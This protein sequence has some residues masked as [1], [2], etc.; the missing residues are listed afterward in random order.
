MVPHAHPHP[1][2]SARVVHFTEYGLPI[3]LLLSIKNKIEADAPL[4]PGMAAHSQPPEA[5]LAPPDYR[6]SHSIRLVVQFNS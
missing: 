5:A 6:P 4:R 1:A 3:Y 2:V